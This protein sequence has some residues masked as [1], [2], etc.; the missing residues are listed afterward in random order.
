MLEL[1]FWVFIGIPLILLCVG[2][3]IRV[4]CEILMG[5]YDLWMHLATASVLGATWVVRRCHRNRP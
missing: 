1:L 3:V 2:L 5:L 4:I